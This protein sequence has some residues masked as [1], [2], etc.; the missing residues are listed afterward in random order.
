M[1][2][3]GL[4]NTRPWSGGGNAMYWGTSMPRITDD[5]PRVGAVA[6]W[7]ANAGP[8]GSVGHVAYVERVV[9]ADE[10][11]VSQDSWGGDFSWAVVTRS[12]GNWPSGFVHFN[13]LPLTN[14]TP[15]VID[16]VAKVG[17]VLSSTPGAWK[18]AD[19]DVAYQWFADGQRIADADAATLRLTKARLDQQ[20]TVTTTASRLGYPTRTSTSAPTEAVLPGTLKNVTAP[21]LSGEAR[22]DSTLALDTGSWTPTPDALTVLWLANGQPIEGVTGEPTLTLTPDLV[23]TTISATVTATREGYAAVTATTAPTEPVAPGTFAVTTPPSILGVPEFGQTLTVDTGAFRPS[24]A[25]VAIQW[26]RDGAPIDGA[27]GPSYQIQNVDL[28]ARISVR[29]TLSRAGYTESTVDSPAT[30]PV[31][32]DPRI[33]VQTERLKHKVRVTVTVLADGVDFVTGPVVVRL[34]GVAREVTLRNGTATVVLKDLPPGKR[35]MTVRYA[36]SDTVNRLVVTRQVR[37]L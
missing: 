35:T 34:A 23:G 15:P 19:V 31:K 26:L 12:S 21:V 33:R 25:A 7:K 27:T 24:D 37:V 32:T 36:G 2:K 30:A 6:W 8:A 20:I 13:D 16:G 11:I 9:S 3:S 1:V 14:Q 29:V 10:V 28:G 5:V 22:V 18:P 17:S 4:P